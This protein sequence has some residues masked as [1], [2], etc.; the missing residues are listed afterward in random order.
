MSKTESEVMGQ[1]VLVIKKEMGLRE[2]CG[3]S[4]EVGLNARWVSSTESGVI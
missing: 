3:N 1:S 2:G 4:T